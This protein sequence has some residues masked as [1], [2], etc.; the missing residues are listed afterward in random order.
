MDTIFVDGGWRRVWMSSM[1][2]D[3]SAMAEACTK[4]VVAGG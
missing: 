2:D 4:V 3:G 1:T